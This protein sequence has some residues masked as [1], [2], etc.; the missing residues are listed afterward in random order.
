MIYEI[1]NLEK[2]LFSTL[3]IGKTRSQSAPYRTF[4]K[5]L[6]NNKNN[7]KTFIFRQLPQRTCVISIFKFQ[8]IRIRRFKIIFFFAKVVKNSINI[9][10]N[11]II[12]W[13]VNSSSI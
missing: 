5:G 1:L 2:N 9:P 12:Q 13:K 8:F 6:S 11:K 4:K 10:V 3:A 7:N